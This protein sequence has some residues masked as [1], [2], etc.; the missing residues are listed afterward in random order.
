MDILRDSADC[1][2]SGVYLSQ[3]EVAFLRE[4]GLAPPPLD[5]LTE[6]LP[7]KEPRDKIIGQ[8]DKVVC[9]LLPRILSLKH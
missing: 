1:D 8:F 9:N 6:P 7:E 5:D 4:N 2:G 3:E